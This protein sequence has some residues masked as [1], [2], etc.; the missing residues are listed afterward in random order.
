M[1]QAE[2]SPEEVCQ[3]WV[4]HS[5]Y[6]HTYISIYH[7][8]KFILHSLKLRFC[9][10]THCLPT[11]TGLHLV[12]HLLCILAQT[13][14]IYLSNRPTGL[15][16]QL[17]C[18]VNFIAFFLFI[19]YGLFSTSSPHSSSCHECHV[20]KKK[21]LLSSLDLAKSQRSKP[22]T[23]FSHTFFKLGPPEQN[24]IKKSF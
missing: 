5:S 9:W 22:N 8:I 20:R 15:E 11:W 1:W 13:Y 12:L 19:T 21:L 18:L 7:C 6:I 17:A 23:F 14:E 2:F 16:F 24:L 3:V 10:Q 4:C